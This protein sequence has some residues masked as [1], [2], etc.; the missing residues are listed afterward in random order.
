MGGSSTDRIER[1]VELK[2]SP[3]RVWRALSDHE[4]FGA[5]FGVVL[6]GPFA[7]GQVTRGKILYPGY[8]HLTMEVEVVAME[9]EKRFAYRWHPYA[10]DAGRDY[11]HETPTL[12]EFVLEPIAGGTRLTVSESGFDKIPPE[13][14]DEAFRMNSGGWDEQ[15]KNIRAHVDG[16]S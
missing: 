10:V 11:T 8:E 1:S 3:A 4:E 12:V 7:V 13:R 15:V 9:R 5:W 14:R 2:A 6:D 16:A